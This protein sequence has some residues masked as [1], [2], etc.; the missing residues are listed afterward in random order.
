MILF[1]HPTPSS[2]PVIQVATHH[3]M[4]HQSPT[5]TTGQGR[6]PRCQRDCCNVER[7]CLTPFPR[8]QLLQG[9]ETKYNWFSGVRIIIFYWE[10]Q[11]QLHKLWW[12]NVTQDNQGAKKS[13]IKPGRDEGMYFITSWILSESTGWSKQ[14]PDLL[15]GQGSQC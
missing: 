14:D 4:R 10:A 2:M 6:L 11:K 7:V 15:T 1:V 5:F 13:G 9:L 3:V 12:W 8:Q